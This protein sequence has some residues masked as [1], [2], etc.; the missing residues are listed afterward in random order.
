MSETDSPI[1]S[2][3]YNSPPE[4]PI[5][6][7]LADKARLPLI[8]SMLSLIALLGLLFVPYIIVMF[9]GVDVSV[10]PDFM[11]GDPQVFLRVIAWYVPHL[12]LFFITLASAYIGYKLIVAS[13]ASPENPIPPGNYRLLAPLIADGKSESI[14]QYVRLSSLSGFTGTFTKLGL[15]GLPLTTVA[16]T[17]IFAGLSLLPVDDESRK[18]FMD[19]TKLVLGAFIG[20]FVQRQV[21]Q[22]RASGVENAKGVSRDQST[23]PSSSS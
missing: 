3:N 15:T 20:S 8:I 1:P 13:G 12:M 22:R 9:P 14:D 10:R 7:D 18:N 5:D 19:L 17:L 2:G 4:F 23:A 11:P 21:E 16:L 6:R